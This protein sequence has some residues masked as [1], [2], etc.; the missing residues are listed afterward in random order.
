MERARRKCD[1][2]QSKMDRAP[3]ALLMAPAC[4]RVCVCTHTHT[5]REG[6]G[7]CEGDHSHGDRLHC[8][9]KDSF[10]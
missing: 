10:S 9:L 6:E 3:T 7:S 8:W 1:W 4:V 2:T 5:G